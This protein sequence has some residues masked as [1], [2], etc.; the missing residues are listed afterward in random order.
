MR[1]Q[2]VKRDGT[3]GKPTATVK[4]G[5]IVRVFL[6]AGYGQSTKGL[7]TLADRMINGF[8]CKDLSKY[9]VIKG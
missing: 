3:L 5:K 1:I 4:D 2:A 8:E 9:I 7:C 6:N